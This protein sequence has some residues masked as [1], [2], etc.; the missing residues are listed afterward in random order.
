MNCSILQDLLRIY[1]LI[2][3]DS[4]DTITVSKAFT[5]DKGCLNILEKLRQKLH[6]IK[7]WVKNAL[8][9]H[10]QKEVIPTL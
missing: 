9:N 7:I 10:A 4:I 8:H 5:G 2:M 1:E 3:L 6:E